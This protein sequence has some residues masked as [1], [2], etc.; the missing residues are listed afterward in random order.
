M[1]GLIV[2][3]IVGAAAFFL[4]RRLYRAAAGKKGAAVCDKCGEVG[5]KHSH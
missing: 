1:Q 4:G 2:L 5:G 3:I